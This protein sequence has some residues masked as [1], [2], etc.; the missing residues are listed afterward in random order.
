VL[1]VVDSAR[2]YFG[3]ARE[4]DAGVVLYELGTLEC[5]TTERHRAIWIVGFSSPIILRSVLLISFWDVTYFG[6]S[7][8]DSSL[9]NILLAGVQSNK[10]WSQAFR[11]EILKKDFFG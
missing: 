4:R 8:E 7:S 2:F 11:T 10:S 1:V 5:P 9:W 6:F 3:V